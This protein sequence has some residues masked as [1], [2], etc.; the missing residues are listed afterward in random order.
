MEPRKRLI[1][2]EDE[3]SICSLLQAH[4]SKHYHIT[5]FNDAES[6]LDALSTLG[7]AHLFIIDYNLP[8]KN[9]SDLFKE[10]KS[11]LPQAK[12]ILVTGFLSP[13]QAEREAQAGF[14][15]L[16]LKPFQI[17]DFMDNINKVLAS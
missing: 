6:C 16:I 1:I 15:A 12:F 2:I 17:Q 13:E 14:D 7:N 5:V 4:L 11:Q 8:Q 10:L 9:G 3:I